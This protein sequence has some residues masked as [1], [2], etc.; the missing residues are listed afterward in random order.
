MKVL[1]CRTTSEPH[2]SEIQGPRLSPQPSLSY[3]CLLNTWD[4]ALPSGSAGGG[5]V[6]R[7]GDHPA[8]LSRRGL[9]LRGGRDPDICTI[10]LSL[11]KMKPVLPWFCHTKA[12]PPCGPASRLGVTLKCSLATGMP[13]GPHHVHPDPAL[14]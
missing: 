12:A 3:K 6:H 13:R 11:A 5:L 2:I 9:A 7:K 10:T 1:F 14:S 4:V 8:G